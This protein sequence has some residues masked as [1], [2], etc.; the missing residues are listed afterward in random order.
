MKRAQDRS[1][2][3]ATDY[4]M[5][6]WMIGVRILAGTGNIFLWHHAETGFAAHPASYSM[7]T[8]GS[9]LGG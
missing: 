3:M 6:Y 1:V 2:D 7:G 4:R 5:D 9:F 8:G